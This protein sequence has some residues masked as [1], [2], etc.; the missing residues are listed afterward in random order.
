M[1]MTY[2]PRPLFCWTMPLA[3]LQTLLKSEHLWISIL[4]TFFKILFCCIL[5]YF[6]CNKNK[7]KV[8][9]NSNFKAYYLHLDFMEMVRVLD[10][11]HKTIRDYR[12]SS[13]ILKSINNINSVW[14]VVPE[15]CLKG[16]WDKLL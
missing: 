4:F 3:I 10:R 15:K 2:Q 11:S 6:F 8:L 7:Q 14:E 13:D 12:L 9:G 16:M 5:L 1:R